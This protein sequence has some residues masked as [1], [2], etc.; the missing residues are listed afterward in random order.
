[1]HLAWWTVGLPTNAEQTPDFESP[2]PPPAPP[3]ELLSP[4]EPPPWLELEAE[5]EGRAPPPWELCWPEDWLWLCEGEAD[6]DCEPFW[7]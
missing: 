1:M 6:D 5:L 7:P 2:P 3:L 4:P